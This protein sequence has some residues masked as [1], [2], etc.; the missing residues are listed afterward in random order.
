MNRIVA[1]YSILREALRRITRQG[2]RSTEWPVGLSKYNNTLELIMAPASSGLEHTL[3]IVLTDDFTP[4]QWLSPDCAGLLL[5][6]RQRR[7]GQATGYLVRGPIDVE[8]LDSVQIVGP[9]MH[10]IA[11]A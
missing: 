3:R 10:T 8:P 7:R 2:E 4:P 5:V 11:L 6:G 9:G 1:P